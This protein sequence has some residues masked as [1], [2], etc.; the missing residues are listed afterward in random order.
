MKI[1]SILIAGISGAM[2]ALTWNTPMVVGW[3]VAFCG[4]I[5]HCFS[6]KEVSHGN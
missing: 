2:I 3:A 4:W 1:L 5:P 6:D